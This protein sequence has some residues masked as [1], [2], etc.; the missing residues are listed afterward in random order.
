MNKKMLWCLCGLSLVACSKSETVSEGPRPAVVITVQ[1]GVEAGLRAYSGEVRA[2]HEVD[3]APQR[4]CNHRR[5]HVA[6]VVGHQ[7]RRSLDGD[8]LGAAHLQPWA[9]AKTDQRGAKPSDKAVKHGRLRVG[10]GTS[11]TA[12]VGVIPAAGQDQTVPSPF[13]ASPR[14]RR[15]ASGSDNCSPSTVSRAITWSLSASL[16]GTYLPWPRA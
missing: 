1:D 14:A 5:V 2:R 15:I 16:R 10:A 13:S 7:H 11:T 9:G 8:V 12:I 4:H 6:G 3:L